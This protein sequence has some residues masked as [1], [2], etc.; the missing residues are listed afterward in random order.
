MLRQ[1]VITNLRVFL[2]RTE[3]KGH[4]VAAFN[5]VAM[6]LN[7]EE[8]EARRKLAAVPTQEDKAA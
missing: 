8:N 7:I 6:A 1:Q 3:L 4:E 2:S 5:E